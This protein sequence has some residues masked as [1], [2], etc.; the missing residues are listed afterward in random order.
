MW[1]YVSGVLKW[2]F[3]TKIKLLQVLKYK[4]LKVS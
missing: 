3:K 1:I 4:D 2:Y